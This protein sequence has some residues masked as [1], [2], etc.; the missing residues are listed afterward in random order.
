MDL[1]S[2]FTPAKRLVVIPVPPGVNLFT[3]FLFAFRRWILCL[4]PSAIGFYRMS[5]SK[6][7]SLELLVVE[8]HRQ[9]R[10]LLCEMLTVLGHT[11]RCVETAEE[12]LSAL[13]KKK[14]DVLLADINLPGMSG[15]ELASIA[16][17]ISPGIGIVFAT[18]FGYLV[19]DKTDF[20]FILLPKPY[21]LAQ[22]KN[23]LARAYSFHDQSSL[24]SS[25][26]QSQH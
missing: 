5:A 17:D 14:F 23:V 12:A 19:S 3:P 6:N 24:H 8:D 16:V 10:Q 18:G 25:Q 15:I 26:S 1:Y 11:A 9:S 13:R 2:F 21:G 22:L 7:L 20:D 4:S